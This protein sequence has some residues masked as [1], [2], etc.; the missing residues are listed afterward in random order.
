VKPAAFDYTRPNTVAEARAALSDGSTGARIL[1]G[2]QSLVPMLNLRLSSVTLLID[3]RQIDALRQTTESAESVAFGACIRHGEIED[4]LVPDPAM[5]LMR[6]VARHLAY[7][8]VRNRGTIGGSV[9]LEDPSADW[10]TALF[11]LGASYR[12]AGVAGERTIATDQMFG[13]PYTTALA[14]SDI[15]TAIVVPKLTRD[16]RWGYYKVIRKAGEYPVTIAS[17]VIDPAREYCSVVLGG[18]DHEPRR[19][20]RTEDFLGKA[21]RWSI[22]LEDRLRSAIRADLSAND[23]GDTFY[24]VKL[25]ETAVLRAVTKAME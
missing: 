15:L 25:A 19:L 14:P 22:D 3:I 2:G 24:Q 13:G 6:Y 20:N 1:A 23:R 11:S 12:A 4:G 7:R 16:A 17:A 21:R 9:A 5:G 10:L 18:N 8:A